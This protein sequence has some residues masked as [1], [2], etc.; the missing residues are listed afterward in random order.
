M[1]ITDSNHLR[2]LFEWNLRM[3]EQVGLSYDHIEY[4]NGVWIGRFS[5]VS[6]R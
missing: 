4:G 2:G 5:L 1:V 6:C 3:A